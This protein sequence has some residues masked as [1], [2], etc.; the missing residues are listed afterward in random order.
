MAHDF[1]TNDGVKHEGISSVKLPADEVSTETVEYLADNEVTKNDKIQQTKSVILSTSGVVEPDAGYDA[2]RSV[3][4]TVQGGGE[5]EVQPVKSVTMYESGTV[6]PDDGYD[7]MESVNV[8]IPGVEPVPVNITVSTAG[9]VT[10]YG[11]GV[12]TA[13]HQLSAADDA[14]FVAAKWSVSFRRRVQGWIVC[15]VR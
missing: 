12:T 4:V 6:T 2:V 11:D 14:D 3:S 7:A 13:T 15:H 8:T 10:A 5:V 1:Y 9:V